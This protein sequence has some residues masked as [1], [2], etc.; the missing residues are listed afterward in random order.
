MSATAVKGW[1]PGAWRPMQSGDG[2]I[3]RIRPRGGRL[4]HAQAA[5]LAEL[6]ERFGNGL[7][8][9]TNRANLQLRGI[10]DH[11]HAPLLQGLA[12]LD[13][14][15]ADAGAESRRNIVVAPFW[16]EHDETRSIAMELEIALSVFHLELPGKFGFAVDCGNERALAEAPADIRIERCAMGDIIVRADSAAMG[17]PVARTEAVA[18]ALALA[19][20]FVAS[21]GVKDGRGRMAAHLGTGARLPTALAAS[22]RPA[23]AMPRPRPGLVGGGALVGIAFGQLSA[24]ALAL[25]ARRSTGLRITPWRMFLV[26]SPQELPHFEG[27]VTTADDPRLAIDACTGAPVCPQA[28]ADTRGLANALAP[29][30]GPG[31]SLHVSGCA[32]GCAHPGIAAIT[33]V[34]TEDGFD[35]V[36]GGSAGDKP[37]VHG[38][39]RD[40]LL[41]DPFVLA[42]DF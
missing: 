10:S 11:G 21:G 28:H 37:L 30:L 22:A 39:T 3:V 40:Q 24:A 20:W 42:G 31:A 36:R 27:L 4:S 34:A 15:D 32:K 25:L 8:D 13:L 38:L 19:E 5:G 23:P 12:E 2:L 14:L 18:T 33:L 17:R 26:E 16:S 9:L 6:S 1:C 41:A 35:L 29:H 7:I